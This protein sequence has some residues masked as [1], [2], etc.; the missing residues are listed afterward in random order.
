MNAEEYV[1]ERFGRYLKP[2]PGKFDWCLAAV[3][4]NESGKMVSLRGPGKPTI[5]VSETGVWVQ[6]R[7]LKPDGLPEHIHWG[8][9]EVFKKAIREADSL[10]VWFGVQL[11]NVGPDKFIPI[12]SLNR[13]GCEAYA[14][15][16]DSGRAELRW[17]PDL[18]QE[19]VALL[20]ETGM[21]KIDP[22][23]LVDAEMGV[24]P[25][26]GKPLT[27]DQARASRR[28]FNLISLKQPDAIVPDGRRGL[29]EAIKVLLEEGK[30]A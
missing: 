17:R 3:V 7:F 19:V 9:G 18:A 15:Y 29:K 27:K 11:S 10:G 14:F 6:T 22:F 25:L 30:D 16:L 4:K 20:R 1:F 2:G 13:P 28:I 24:R 12:R 5:L 21:E 23:A 26:R 8:V